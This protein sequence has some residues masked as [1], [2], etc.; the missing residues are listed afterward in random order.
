MPDVTGALS[1]QDARSN[2]DGVPASDV[3]KTWLSDILHNKTGLMVEDL[4]VNR[5][6]ARAMLEQAGIEVEEAINGGEAVEKVQ[7]KQYELIVM[8]IQVP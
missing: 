6:V 7:E 3:K 4:L 5:V 2:Q 8:D 1:S